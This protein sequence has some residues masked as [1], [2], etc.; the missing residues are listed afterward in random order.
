MEIRPPLKSIYNSVKYSESHTRNCLRELKRAGW[1]SIV[2]NE[3][4][5]R[6]R[7]VVVTDKMARSVREYS[8]YIREI[9]A[10]LESNEG[11]G[12]SNMAADDG[13][14]CIDVQRG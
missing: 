6:S 4:D 11:A 13:Q 3:I 9:F 2:G 5:K 10:A 1:I 8:S 12:N 7:H 14:N